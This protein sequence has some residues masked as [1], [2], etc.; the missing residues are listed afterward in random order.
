MSLA[1][2]D[3]VQLHLCSRFLVAVAWTALLVFPESS[4]PS[5]LTLSRRSSL[6]AFPTISTRSRLTTVASIVLL[7]N[8]MMETNS[9]F[10]VQV[11]E[12]LT[13]F[14][15]LKAFNLVKDVTSGLSKVIN[16]QI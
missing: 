7:R 9:G 10:G 14:G 8:I 3:L 15:Q 12:L 1:L 11:K 13:S 4:A 5:F 6:A 16:C 2:V